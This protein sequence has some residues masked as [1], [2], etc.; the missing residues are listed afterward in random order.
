MEPPDP[1][2]GG[3]TYASPPANSHAASQLT[4]ILG[5]PDTPTPSRWNIP[6]PLG[7]VMGENNQKKDQATGAEAQEHPRTIGASRILGYAT[8]SHG[9][10]KPQQQ[11]TQRP[12]GVKK[13]PGTL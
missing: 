7:L 2:G 10:A 6:G 13:H 8:K 5:V 9:I 12:L 4:E 3:V 11:A 1:H